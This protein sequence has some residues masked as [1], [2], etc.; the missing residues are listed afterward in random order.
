MQQNILTRNRSLDLQ[1]YFA[2]IYNYMAG[3]LLMSAICAWLSVRQPLFGLFYKASEQGVSYSILGWISI[4]AP[5]IIIFLIG[6]AINKLNIQ[7]ARLYFWLFSALM[8]VSL[9]NIFLFF[10]G[11]AIFQAFLV[12]AGSFLGLSLY[13]YTTK[14]DLSSWGSFLVMGLVGVVIASLINIFVKSAQFDFVLNI[15]AVF[16][17][18][19]LTAYDTNKL[20]YMYNANDSNEIAQGK[21]IYGALNLYLDFINLFRLILYFLNNR[22]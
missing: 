3:G 14:R 12:T 2:R 9:G 4:F 1:S 21:A 13:G 20:R 16:V 15:I 18:V 17:F 5:L 22:R 8:G 7:Q 11:A 10:S 6:H 19:G